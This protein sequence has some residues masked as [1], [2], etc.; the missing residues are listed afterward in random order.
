MP[1]EDQE[2]TETRPAGES[3]LR[4]QLTRLTQDVTTYIPPPDVSMTAGVLTLAPSQHASC[5]TQRARA[6]GHVVIG[7]VACGRSGDPAASAIRWAHQHG[8]VQDELL[9]RELTLRPSVWGS[10]GDSTLNWKSCTSA[11]SAAA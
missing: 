9:G 7:C 4:N 5:R 11:I 2:T 3:L 10:G 1:K 8:A 6:P